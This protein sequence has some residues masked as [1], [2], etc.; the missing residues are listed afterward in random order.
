[1]NHNVRDT[2]HMAGDFEW[3]AT[4]AAR[5]YA[6]HGVKFETACEIFKDPFAIEFLDDRA[7]YG[8]D[9]FIILGAFDKHVLLVVYTMRDGIIHIISARG[10]EPPEKRKYHEDNG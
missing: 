6:C 3:E 5:S 8:E 2:L 7:D 9:R 1:M 10:A 4:R